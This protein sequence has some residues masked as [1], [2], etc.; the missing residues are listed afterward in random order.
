MIEMV[1]ALQQQ[2]L[3]DHAE[4]A[5][6]QRRQHQRRPE[7]HVEHAQQQPGGEGAH[8]ELRAVREVDDV[9]HAEDHGEAQAQ[10][11]VEGAVDQPESRPAPSPHTPR[12]ACS[13]P[14]FCSTSAGG[15]H[16]DDAAVLHHVVAVG[17]GGGEME[18]LL[19]QQDGEAAALELADDLADALHDHRR[20]PLGRLVEQ[21][22]VGA[23]AQDAADRQ[24]LLLAARQLGA[25]AAPP[26]LQVGEELVD[27]AQAHAAR[28][29]HRRQQ[30]V[31]LDA[32]AREDA[33][34][35]RAVGEA[36]PRDLVGRLAR[37][38]RGPRRRP[39][40]MRFSTMPMTDFRV[41]VLPAPLRPSS[42]TSSPRPISKPTPCRMCDS[43]YQACRPAT[44][45]RAP[46]P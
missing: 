1:D 39:S 38:S 17:H 15:D 18:V 22:Q 26:L 31:L 36:Q 32:E 13:L 42:V 20:Q 43:P 30:Q 5:D 41:V 10:H 28:L 19:D 37:P 24:H 16:V 3:E 46:Q 40:P 27:L 7:R 23:G 21:Q 11:G 12:Y 35:L 6:D 29:D 45:S 34:L 4:Q 44:L 9:Q 25:L 33:A 14:M 2:P 8:H